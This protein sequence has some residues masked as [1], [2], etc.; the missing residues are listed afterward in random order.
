[1]LNRSYLRVLPLLVLLLLGSWAGRRPGDGGSAAPGGPVPPRPAVAAAVDILP[2][3]GL[4]LAPAHRM[5]WAGA[6][7]RPAVLARPGGLPPGAA[8]VCAGLRARRGAAE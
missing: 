8:V 1:M 2:T 3:A 5:R 4:P 6:S 7:G